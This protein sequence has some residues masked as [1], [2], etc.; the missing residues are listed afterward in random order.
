MTEE[1]TTLP[2]IVQK[3][4]ELV[5]EHEAEIRARGF[6]DEFPTYL[7]NEAINYFVAAHPENL[8]MLLGDKES[9]HLWHTQA[10][11][12]NLLER[13]RGALVGSVREE[14]IREMKRIRQEHEVAPA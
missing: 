12:K 2:D 10:E 5:R 3:A 13:A 1:K 8:G 9:Y 6:T 4:Q 11:G 14:V 7:A